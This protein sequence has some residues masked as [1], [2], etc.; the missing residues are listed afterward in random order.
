MRG[1]GAEPTFAFDS[2]RGELVEHGVLGAGDS[3]DLGSAPYR[4]PGCEVAGADPLRGRGELPSAA[5]RCYAGSTE[6]L[7]RPRE[8][9]LLFELLRAGG[10][11]VPRE[12][13]MSAVWPDTAPSSTKALDVTMAMLRRRLEIAAE[14]HPR[15]HQLPTVTT[16]R[17]YGYR[18]D[19]PQQTEQDVRSKPR[20]SKRLTGPT[21]GWPAEPG[22]S[23]LQ[24]G[25]VHPRPSPPSVRLPAHLPRPATRLMV[26]AMTTTPSRYE[27]RAC[28]SAV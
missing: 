11:A 16:L 25:T 14:T 22:P 17:G 7:L 27:T 23:G 15:Q 20:L 21:T 18:L 8:F 4:R 6:L 19:P 12:H 26:V 13:L 24:A 5:R 9:A 1:V 28:R 2:R 3:F 10:R